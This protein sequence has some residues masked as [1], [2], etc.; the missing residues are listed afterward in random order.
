MVVKQWMYREYR[1]DLQL[2]GA[3][4]MPYIYE[5]GNSEKLSYT[6]VVEM[7]HGQRTAEQAA[8][9]FI[10]ARIEKKTPH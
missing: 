10:D 7:K 1:I 4:F 6:P 3:D 5:P 8:E 9:A 2:I